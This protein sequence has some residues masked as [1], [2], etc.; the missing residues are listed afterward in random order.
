MLE[1]L[2]VW[3]SETV[4]IPEALGLVQGSEKAPKTTD[5]AM[6]CVCCSLNLPFWGLG[7][8]GF[9]SNVDAPV[10]SCS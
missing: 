7:V 5:I 9:S 4:R 6:S 10:S 2:G 8:W 3:G 1:S